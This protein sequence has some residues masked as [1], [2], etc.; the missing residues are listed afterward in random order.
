MFDYRQSIFSDGCPDSGHHQIVV[1]ER[2]ISHQDSTLMTIN[3]Q[4]AFERIDDVA[5]D[6]DLLGLMSE[7]AN[8]VKVLIS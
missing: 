8:A 3:D 5:T 4:L 2:V 6:A 1:R 7:T